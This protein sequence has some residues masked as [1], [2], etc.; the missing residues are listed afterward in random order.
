MT[1]LKLATRSDTQ[2]MDGETKQNIITT[3]YIGAAKT[4]ARS[5]AR[6]MDATVYRRPRPNA[7]R[8]P[9]LG[10]MGLSSSIRWRRMVSRSS[11]ILNLQV[12]FCNRNRAD[13]RTT[14][15]GR[16]KPGR[17]RHMSTVLREQLRVYPIVLLEIRGLTLNQQRRNVFSWRLTSIMELHLRRK[18]SNCCP[19]HTCASKAGPARIA[20]LMSSLAGPGRNAFLPFSFP[21]LTFF[22]SALRIFIRNKNYLRQLQDVGF[23]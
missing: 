16:I 19:S 20:L 22:S 12:V 6:R 5:D 2:N 15:R 17:F 10:V 11:R 1:S 8:T 14:H 3:L 23:T 13:R 4:T 18:L 21:R 9:F 7:C